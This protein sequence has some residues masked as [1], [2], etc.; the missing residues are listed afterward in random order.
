M[1]IEKRGP[2]SYRARMTVNGKSY[3]VSFDHKPTESEAMLKLSNKI[4]TVI[5]RQRLTFK[6]AANEYC[7]LKENVL[8]PA[9]YREYKNTPK[10]LS[11]EFTNLYLDQVTQLQIQHEINKLSK[12]KA[13]KTVKNY[14]SF[15]VSVM[16]MYDE[17]FNVKVKLPQAIP[18]KTY[19]PTDEELK[20]LFEYAKEKSDGMFY[21]PIVL[22]S[23]GMRR[24]EICALDPGDIEGNIVYIHKG[25]VMNVNNKWVVKEYPKNETSVRSIP[26]PQ[27]IA[28]MIKA[29]GYVY[30]GHPNSISEFIDD[31]CVKFNIKHFTL[32]KL[33]HYFCSRL[34]SE[35]IDVETIIAL[36]GH[37]TDFVMKNIYRHSI[38]SKVSEASDKLNSILFS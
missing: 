7:K 34:S 8:S 36:S 14:Y 37:K 38:T 29:Q 4:E 26:I 20:K 32:H 23:Y 2:N 22:G 11:K 1:K 25:K 17:S 6:V 31:F 18:K 9:T 10:R 15:I 30:E 21:I 13:P 28:D 5:E 33:R 35:N 27:E 12:D 3:S 16:R 24:S 19:I